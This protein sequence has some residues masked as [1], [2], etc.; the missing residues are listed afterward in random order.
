MAAVQHRP[1]LVGAGPGHSASQ[2]REPSAGARRAERL[3]GRA[4]TDTPW[5]ARTTLK[6][7]FPKKTIYDR[8]LREK[9]KPRQAVN[10]LRH[11]LFSLPL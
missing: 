7:L 1:P 4:A 9:N 11:S 2:A 6:R 8:S 5:R 3:R 10:T